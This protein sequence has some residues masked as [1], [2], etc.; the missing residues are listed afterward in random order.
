MIRKATF[1]DAHTIFKL[2]L[3]GKEHLKAMGI[4]QWQDGYP[5]LA[6]IQE[7]IQKE[8]CYVYS[9][10][11]TIIASCT[12]SFQ[13]DPFYNT[14]EGSWSSDEP[15]GVIHRIIVSS[16]HKKMGIATKL[17]N[18]AENLC[19]NNTINWMRIDT[20]HDNVA[21]LRC[22]KNNNYTECGTIYVRNNEPRLAFDKNLQS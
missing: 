15:Y 14:I 19:K 10:H 9:H 1:D 11:N 18:F 8:E 7:D 16:T 3:E 4:N 20:H 6:T 5:D 12:I 21:M 2:I 22:I 13:P 17:L